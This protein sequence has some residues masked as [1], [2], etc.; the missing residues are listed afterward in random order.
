MPIAVWLVASSSSEGLIN[1]GRF[2]RRTGLTSGIFADNCSRSSDCLVRSIRLPRGFTLQSKHAPVRIADP[3][4][5]IAHVIDSVYADN[6]LDK[7]QPHRHH[8]TCF[9]S[10]LYTSS[11]ADH[12]SKL[13]SANRLRAL[14]QHTRPARV[15]PH[16]LLNRQS[17]SRILAPG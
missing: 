15:R 13:S 2:L 3:F 5:M 17:R 8:Y 16:S 11:A 9:S 1:A 6:V 10:A 7:R 4:I 12:P 14:A